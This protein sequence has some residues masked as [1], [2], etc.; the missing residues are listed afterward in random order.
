M[1]NIGIA[2][3][4]FVLVAVAS[5]SKQPNP[6][7]LIIGDSISNGYTPFVKEELKDIAEV[8]HNP[9]NAK[10]T[11]NGL[12][13]IESWLA[14]GDWDI[15]HFN[16][17]LWDLC[18]RHPDSKV[19]GNRDKVNGTITFGPEEYEKNLN[20]LVKLIKKHSNAELI[21]ATTTFVPEKE[22]GRFQ[23]DAITYNTIAKKIMKANGV[24]IN[25]IFEVS[26]I[27]HNEYGKGIDDV[28]YTEKGYELLGEH[29]SNF[30]KQLIK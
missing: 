24:K 5:S 12:K 28:H 21:F 11:E 27:I 29:V 15:I 3:I 18:Y 7:I 10:H 2:F 9:G 23:E 16:W 26:K 25:D 6:K 22:A 19:Q 13:H 20:T 30:I 17:G 4:L 1:K 8:H 14:A